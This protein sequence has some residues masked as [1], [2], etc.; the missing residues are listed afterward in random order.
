MKSF[1]NEQTSHEDVTISVMWFT[2]LN[3]GW[4][5]FKRKA[6]FSFQVCIKFAVN[7]VELQVH[8][9]C[10]KKETTSICQKWTNRISLYLWVPKTQRERFTWAARFQEQDAS[11]S[12]VSAP[13]SELWE[14]ALAQCSWAWARASARQ[15]CATGW[16]FCNACDR[17]WKWTCITVK[18]HRPSTWKDSVYY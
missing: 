9:K 16:T 17:N 10:H 13:R 18:K 4:T 1:L 6:M 12:S 15:D 7:R 14:Q 5:G 8:R 11:S 3:Q 2:K